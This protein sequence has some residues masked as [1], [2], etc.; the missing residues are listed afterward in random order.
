MLRY[1]SIYMH[2]NERAD[3]DKHTTVKCDSYPHDFEFIGELDRM[4]WS[5][6]GN[7]CERETN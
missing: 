7:K 2:A 5:V 4:R 3:T 6:C 1:W